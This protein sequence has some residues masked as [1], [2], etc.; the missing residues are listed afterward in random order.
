MPSDSMDKTVFKQPMPGGDRTIMRPTPGG[1]RGGGQPASDAPVPSSPMAGAAAHHGAYTSEPAV[2][3]RTSAFQADTG[4]NSLTRAASTLIAV[5]EKTR[6]SLN[7]P[8]VGGLH[9]N[10]VYEIRTFEQKARDQGIKPEIVLAAR[11][12][13]CSVLDEAVLNTPWGSESP[14]AQKTLLSVFHN[15]TS[16]GEKFFL[17]LDRMRQSPAENLEFLEFAYILLSLGFEGRYRLDSRGRQ[18]IEQIKDEL[19]SGIRRYRGDY[20]RTLSSSWRGLGNTRSSLTEYLPLWVVAS[21]FAVLLFFGYS[22][23]RYW[24]YDTATPVA[25]EL[26]RIAAPAGDSPE[27]T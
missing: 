2:A 15:E 18:M 5:Y 12:M 19:F 24:L 13:L 14:W 25:Q 21:G 3:P 23:F 1:R 20:E 16:G 9:H 10:L 11:Y 6:Q 8:D 26:E 4:L 22:G 7:H 27:A 17:I